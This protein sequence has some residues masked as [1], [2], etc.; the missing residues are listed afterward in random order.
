MIP[1]LFTITKKGVKEENFLRFFK[2][3]KLISSLVKFT[4]SVIQDTFIKC[5]VK[6]LL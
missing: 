2:C 3:E 5:L 6:T 4:H 1:K